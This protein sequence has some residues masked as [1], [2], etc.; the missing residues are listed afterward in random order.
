VRIIAA[1]NRDLESAI[2]AGTFRQDLFYRLNVFPIDVPP[3]RDRKE[4]IR[5]LVE[6]LTERY[7]SKGGKKI[8]NIDKRTMELLNAY[9]WPGNIREL[10][11]VIE[12]AVILCDGDILSID[13]VWLQREPSRQSV[14]ASNGLARLGSDREKALIESALRESRGQVS[15]PSGA[16]AKLG[17]PRSTLETK[18][19]T[20]GI[21]KHL[22]KS[23]QAS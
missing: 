19:R 22:F 12:R 20:L 4:D 5:L 1:T 21:E 16:A 7:A 9:Q 3:L 15:G 13:E 18:I 2:K 6:Y 8:K 23:H 10:Q 14:T 17:I 11:N